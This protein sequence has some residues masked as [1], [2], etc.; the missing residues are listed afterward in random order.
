MQLSNKELIWK[1]NLK[2]VVL[3]A[4]NRINNRK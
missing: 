3:M 4:N 1:Q 2:E